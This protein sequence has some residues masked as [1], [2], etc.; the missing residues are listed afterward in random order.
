MVRYQKRGF[1]IKAQ[2]S[3][4]DSKRVHFQ[5]LHKNPKKMTKP[6][7]WLIFILIVIVGIML[8]LNGIR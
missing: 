5:R 4:R 8:Y 3:D 1:S 2:R 6:L 7:W